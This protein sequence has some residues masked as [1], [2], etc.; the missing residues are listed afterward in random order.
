MMTTVFDNELWLSIREKLRCKGVDI[1]TLAPP[2]T[3]GT[4]QRCLDSFF[5]PQK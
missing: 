5:Q 1:T 2:Q 3:C 4:A